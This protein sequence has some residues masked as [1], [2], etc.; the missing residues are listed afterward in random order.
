MEPQPVPRKKNNADIPKGALDH[1]EDIRKLIIRIVI[2][3]VITSIVV[4][5]F[6][7]DLLNLFVFGLLSKNF[8]TNRIL[9][10]LYEPFCIKEYPVTFQAINPTEQFTKAIS[11]SL[12]AGF[13]LS[14]PIIIYF[15]WNYIKPVLKPAEKKS[16]KK[17]LIP[18]TLLFFVGVS[19]SY[20]VLLPFMFNFFASFSLNENIEN[21]WRIGSI[22][23]LMVQTSLLIG[24]LFELPVVSYYLGLIGFISSKF[25]GRYRRHAII[26]ILFLAGFLTPSPDVI[27]QLVLALPMYLLFEVSISVVKKAERKRIQE[28]KKS[29]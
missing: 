18:V 13:I 1:M 26:V 10:S 9:C 23:G 11:F 3:I 8:I 22:I 17:V 29:K 7:K 20:F 27:S 28:E 24:L 5:I 19:F 25:L 16:V 2:S 12:F 6:V 21:Q 14:F 4:F 15:V